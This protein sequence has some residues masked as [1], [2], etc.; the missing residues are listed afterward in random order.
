MDKVF[1]IV[2][3]KA[4]NGL[5]RDAE[6]FA[7]TLGITRMQLS[8][9]NYISRNENKT[10]IFQKDIEKE[11]NI[12]K[13]S[14]TSALKL[15]EQKDLII[16]VSLPKDAR[17]KR[18]VL[19]SKSRQLTEQISDYIASVEAEVTQAVGAEQMQIVKDGLAKV[20]AF[21]ENKDEI[22]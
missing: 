16:R 19:T 14:A 1:G 10:D 12:R 20:S 9:I 17:L 7:K 21:F 15:M 3:K 22:N 2:V 13:A 8:I 11:F 4:N 5:D 6:K 18:I